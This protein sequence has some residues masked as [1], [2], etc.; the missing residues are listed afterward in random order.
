[1]SEEEAPSRKDKKAQRDADRK[2]KGKKRKH[3]EVEK[4][5]KADEQS[6]FERDFLPLDSGPVVVKDTDGKKKSKKDASRKRKSEKLEESAK[7]NETKPDSKSTQPKS[8]KR[9]KDKTDA[10]SGVT[11][12]EDAASGD[13]SHR[14]IL[15]VGNLPYGATD[16]TIRAHFKKLE[17]FTLRHRTDPKTGKSKGFAFL[18]F[19]KYDR[20]K[21]CMKL[22]HHSMFDPNKT[23]ATVDEAGAGD[24]EGP[25]KQKSAKA[26]KAAR[27][28][29]VELTAGGGGKAEGRK[30]KIRVKNERL[31]EQRQRRAEAERK[32]REKKAKEEGEVNDVKPVKPVKK[33]T[34]KAEEATAVREDM[35]G[36]HPS[37]LARIAA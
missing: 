9:K 25:A 17:P 20:M 24:D 31:G 19:E 18:E 2:K 35:G 34:K 11:A 8:K 7:S 33:T 14:F 21:T 26:S 37:R 27:R 6:E 30:E 4:D 29:N 22:Y 10:T 3:D 36:M 1:M 28:I 16:A 32:E 23:E 15:F 5:E 12:G 13:K